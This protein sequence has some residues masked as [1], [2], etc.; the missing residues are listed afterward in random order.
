MHK[1][2]G[3][4][5][6]WRKG[7][8]RRG[9]QSLS[10][11][12]RAYEGIEVKIRLCVMKAQVEE[13]REGERLMHKKDGDKDQSGG[14]EEGAEE[15]GLLDI[16]KKSVG[17]NRGEDQAVCKESAEKDSVLDGDEAARQGM[18]GRCYLVLMRLCVDR[19]E[20]LFPS[21]FC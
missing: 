9:K 16:Y 2:G 1:K 5:D 8:R 12:K 14:K 4:K 6:Q 18:E 10:Y 15:N 21:R 11:I 19:C 17:R 20:A 3:D 13:G 7:G